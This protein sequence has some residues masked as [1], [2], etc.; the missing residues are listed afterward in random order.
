[1]GRVVW[2]VL[3]LIWCGLGGVV[4]VAVKWHPW[5]TSC[6]ALGWFV[7]A[8]LADRAGYQRALKEAPAAVSH[9]AVAVTTPES[10]SAPLPETGTAAVPA[11]A[12]PLSVELRAA[13]VVVA[14][15]LG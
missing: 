9:P 7:T 10:S 6:T 3:A 13:H 4:L 8:I 14:A 5:L 12:G 11:S 1:M 15:A 2:W